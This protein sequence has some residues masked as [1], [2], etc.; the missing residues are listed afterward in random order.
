MVDVDRRMNVG[1]T[2]AHVAG[3]K[4]LSA[5]AN[6]GPNVPTPLR[7][8]LVSFS[9]LAKKVIERLKKC[10]V[11][12]EKG[13]SDEEF[14][15]VEA[16]FRFTFPPDLRAILQ[17]GLPVGIGF[18]DWRSGGSQ[19]LRMRL[20]LPVAG[21]SY[22][23]ARGRFWWKQWGQR[24]T[25]TENAVKIARNALR[26]V[27][28]LV[29]L[30]GHCYIPS[31]PDLAGN[32]GLFVYQNDVFYCGYDLADF[33]EREAFGC[34]GDKELNF[35]TKKVVGHSLRR[36]KSMKLQRHEHESYFK[37]QSDHFSRSNNSSKSVRLQSAG[38]KWEE[39]WRDVEV[40]GRN[41]DSLAKCSDVSYDKDCN[42]DW[43]RRS[44][45]GPYRRKSCHS[46]LRS[47]DNSPRLVQDKPISDKVLAH[48]ATAA[49][50]PPWLVKT[51]RWIEFWS[52]LAEKKQNSC[53]GS[54]ERLFSSSKVDVDLA[55]SAVEENC[56][57][58][59]YRSMPRWILN[60][61]EDLA[62]VLR[63]GGWREEDIS[64]IVEVSS[65]PFDNE[66]VFFDSQAALEGMLLK[67]DSMS[68]SL[69]RAGWSSQDVSEVFDFDFLLRE[70]RRSAKKL[71]PEFVQR[72]GKLAEYVAQA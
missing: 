9:V 69:R 18:P 41:L 65:T 3:L 64:D 38:A 2:Q 19:Q 7:K 71:S 21:L 6:K 27:P 31:S 66:S 12:V 43:S 45:D 42:P 67:A 63:N 51:P 13:L 23:V 62:T 1:H 28:I 47:A 50:S 4:R 11:S 34:P 39:Y 52:D 5:R 16:E 70:P 10:E 46:F 8:G 35:V 14:A 53:M 72:I 22:E 33:F 68:D 58:L 25:D 57:D 49:P 24:P 44:L 60:Y 40:W 55:K 56:N 48:L 32:P 30:Y 61:L 26:K 29:P 36:E 59:Q 20:N 54:P 17:E 37:E 15:R